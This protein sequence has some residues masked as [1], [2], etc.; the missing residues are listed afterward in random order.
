MEHTVIKFVDESIPTLVTVP[1]GF[2]ERFASMANVEWFAI[3]DNWG[4]G[5]TRHE[6]NRPNP[7]LPGMEV[8]SVVFG[9]I[10]DDKKILGIK[11]LRTS[12][13]WSLVESKMFYEFLEGWVKPAP[14]F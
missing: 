12:M 1:D 11:E 3:T 5:H 13:Q 2:S 8:L 6:P 10:R 9:C 14:P 4:Y 7:S